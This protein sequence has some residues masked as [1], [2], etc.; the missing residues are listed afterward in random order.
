MGEFVAVTGDG[1]NDAPAIKAANIGIAMG[2]GTDVAK[3]TGTMII[4]DDKFKSIVTGIE[5]GR[6]AYNN[7]RKVIYLLISCGL[8]EVLFII[9]S[10]LFD[11]PLPLV[12]V[13]LLWLNL[14]TDGIQDITLSLEKAEREVMNDKP[15]KPNE[16]IF[17]KLLIQE[18]LV[19]GIKIS[20]TVFLFGY[21]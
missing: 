16:S 3:E 4:N 10:I 19:S 1:V 5:E 7:V 2:S 12:A 21:I 6:I 17:D 20:L 9:L 14:V 13:Q 18:T 8:G 15:R 11:Y